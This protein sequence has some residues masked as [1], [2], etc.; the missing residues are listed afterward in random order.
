MPCDQ[1]RITTV[2]LEG[3]DLD[4]MQRALQGLGY[5]VSH[6]GQGLSFQKGF[7]SAGTYDG[8]A[9]SFTRGALDVNTLKRAY[10][11]EVVRTSATRF[12]W[13]VTEKT[14]NR[15]FIVERRGL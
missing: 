4:T 3:A 7:N 5:T 2:E 6:Y 10:S 14:P 1:I 12:G 8:H 11:A 9:F 15:Q 13:K